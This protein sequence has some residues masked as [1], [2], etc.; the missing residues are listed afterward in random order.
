M[1]SAYLFP[2]LLGA[3]FSMEVVV[4]PHD[5]ENMHKDGGWQVWKTGHNKKYGDEGEEKVRYAIWKDNLQRIVEHNKKS[6]SVFLAM[7][8][9]GDLTNTEYRARMLGFKS[10]K[11]SSS[12]GSTFLA[13]ENVELPAAVDWRPKG[14]VTPVKDQGQCGSCWAFSATGSLEGQHFRKTGKLVSLSEQ[15]L[16]DCSRKFGNDGCD[17]GLMDYAFLYIKHNKG[18]DT[19]KSYPYKAEDDPCT[20]KRST[21]GANDTGFVDIKSGSEA[22]LKQAVATVGPISVGIDASHFSFQFY[23]T[24]VYEEDDCSSTELDHGVLAVGYGVSPQGKKYWLVKNSWNTD[25][26]K[27]GYIWMARDY[28]NNCGIATQA[29][30]PLV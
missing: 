17:G 10:K 12:E 16:V 15:N 5:D 26:G 29:S 24:G 22:A 28:N 25:W 21:V 6:T 3:V 7:N 14:Y 27:Q 4:R 20:F 8:K 23:A 18:I 11:P 19:E 1:Y 30:Y 9:F 13:P 2:L